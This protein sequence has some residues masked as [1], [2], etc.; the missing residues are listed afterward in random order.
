MT[1]LTTRCR[2][3]DVER[4]G[5]QSSAASV[6]RNT[7]I[8]PNFL[9]TDVRIGRQLNARARCRIELTVDVF[10][11]FNR[12][13]YSGVNRVFGSHV[14]PSADVSA[15]KDLPPTEPL[16]VSSAYPA[17]QLQIGARIAF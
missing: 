2:R 8:G 14:L 15:R 3:S 16:G 7:G 6:G 11:L 17:R 10:N 12:T 5:I 9:T 4:T 1:R 13:N